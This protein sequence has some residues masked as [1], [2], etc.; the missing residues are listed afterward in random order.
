[1]AEVLLEHLDTWSWL[2]FPQHLARVTELALFDDDFHRVFGVNRAIALQGDS[3]EGDAQKEGTSS[4][5]DQEEGDQEG[6]E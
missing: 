4:G 1:M 3:P 5:G 2:T 6:G